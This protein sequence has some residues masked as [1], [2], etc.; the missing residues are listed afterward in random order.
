[1][2]ALRCLSWAN[3]LISSL[4]TAMDLDSSQDKVHIYSKTG[5]ATAAILVP[6]GEFIIRRQ[7][8]PH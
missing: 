5:R 1:M 8:S 7:N 3:P 4:V 6:P 2:D